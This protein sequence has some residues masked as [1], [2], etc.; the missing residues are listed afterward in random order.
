[1]TG[2][3]TPTT[4]PSNNAMDSD[5]NQFNAPE[6]YFLS[7]TGKTQ[8]FFFFTLFVLFIILIKYSHIF[9]IF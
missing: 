7:G 4:Q 1:M 3:P 6:G 5:A 2:S 9:Y 8:M